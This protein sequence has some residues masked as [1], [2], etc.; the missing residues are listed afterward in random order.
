[1]VR[2]THQAFKYEI[3]GIAERISKRCLFPLDSLNE[4]RRVLDWQC[5]RDRQC[6]V[7]PEWAG[8]DRG[9]ASIHSV[10]AFIPGI[11]F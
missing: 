3:R 1:M 9:E 11:P 8:A 2:S 6:V 10:P 4:P 5:E 7:A